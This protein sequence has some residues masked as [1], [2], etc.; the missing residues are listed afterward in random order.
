MRL[1][2]FYI[3]SCGS[4]SGLHTSSLWAFLAI[5]SHSQGRQRGGT[6]QIGSR[7]HRC[8]CRWCRKSV[9]FDAPQIPAGML[10]FCWIPLDSTGFHWNGTRIHWN[11]TGIQWNP[12]E[13]KHSCRNSTGIQSFFSLYK[14]M[15]YFFFLSYNLITICIIV[16]ISSDKQLI[17]YADNLMNSF[18]HSD[19]NT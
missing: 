6:Q 17:P 11:W 2:I 7:W 16:F 13:F 18:L 5:V 8:I 9:L 1:F 19:L 3:P 14:V 4:L 15:I 10:E 12:V